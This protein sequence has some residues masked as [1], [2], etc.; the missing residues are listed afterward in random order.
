MTIKKQYK[1]IVTFLQENKD[2]KITKALLEQ[3]YTMCESKT[4]GRTFAKDGDQ[5]VAIYCYYHKQWEML[6]QCEYGSKA[7]SST[8]YNTMCKKG[9]RGWTRTQKL[10]KDLDSKILSKIMAEELEASDAKSYKEDKIEK[11][12]KQVVNDESIIET[13]FVEESWLVEQG[14]LK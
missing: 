5:V 3:V 1:D 4:K 13:N 9:V 7:S 10:L 11:I 2:K 6:D 8:G 12:Q 14:F